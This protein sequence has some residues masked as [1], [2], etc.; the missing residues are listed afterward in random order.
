MTNLQ[1]NLISDM[2]LITYL[3]K[4]NVY[5]AVFQFESNL[6]KVKKSE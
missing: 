5:D 1:I 3:T 4:G 2:I 6:Y